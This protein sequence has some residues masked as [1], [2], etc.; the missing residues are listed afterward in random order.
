MGEKMITV[1]TAIVAVLMLGGLLYLGFRLAKV[2]IDKMPKKQKSESSGRVSVKLEGSPLMVRM[3]V[4]GVLALLMLIPLQMVEGIVSERNG[5]YRG[6]LNE[7]ASLW[8]QQQV[9]QGPA[10]VIPYV[11]RVV[12]EE[13]VTDKDGQNRTVTRTRM[14]SRSAV[15]LPE[16][17]DITIDLAE[18][19]RSRGIYSALVYAAEIKLSGNFQLPDINALSDRIETIRWGE[20]YLVMGLSDTRAI[21]RVSPLEWN[22]ETFSFAPGTRI[23]S[24]LPRGFH[25]PVTGVGDEKSTYSF[26]MGLNANGSHGI[27]FAPFGASTRVLMDSSWPHPSF[28]GNVLPSTHEITENGFSAFWE[29]PNLARSYPQAWTLEDQTFNLGEFQAGVDLFEPVF[30]YSK[31]TRAAKYGLL[32]VGLTFLT[33]LIFELTVGVPLHY[34]QYALIGIALSFFYLCLLSLA[35]HISFVLAYSA[36]SAVTIGLIT[37]YAWATLRSAGRAVIVFVLLTALY[38]LLY[39]LLRLEDY[40]L[41]M[42]TGLLLVVIMVLMYFTRN[43]RSEHQAMET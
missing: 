2:L 31:I 15:V 28:Q 43:L 40:A 8:G 39:S 33:F 18:E 16:E 6:V 20:A 1:I 25:A 24:A 11:D 34:V 10:L 13:M 19:Y 37:V 7:I 38:I 21:N 41:L 9:I 42:G 3:L 14:V 32:F 27:R 29:V 5:L 30:L 26:S 17:L 12:T 22:G 23:V 36:A 4:I 35:E